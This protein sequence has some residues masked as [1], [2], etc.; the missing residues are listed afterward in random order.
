MGVPMIG[1]RADHRPNFGCGDF[2]RSWS[3]HPPAVRSP[4]QSTTRNRPPSP[5]TRIDLTDRGKGKVS[6]TRRQ[7]RCSAAGPTRSGATLLTCDASESVQIW[8]SLYPTT[9]TDWRHRKHRH[10]L[11]IILDLYFFDR[12]VNHPYIFVTNTPPHY[13]DFSCPH[14]RPWKTAASGRG[15]PARPAEKEYIVTS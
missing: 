3:H 7:P 15:R 8:W 6:G 12:R 5:S 1:P 13:Y 14:F 10:V 2:R 9:H 11:D 4:G